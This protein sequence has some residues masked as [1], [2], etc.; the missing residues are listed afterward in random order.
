[1]FAEADAGGFISRERLWFV[2]YA[3]ERMGVV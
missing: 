3:R 2:R 1:V